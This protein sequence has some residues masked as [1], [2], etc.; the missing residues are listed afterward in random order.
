[1][2]RTIVMNA[3]VNGVPASVD[4]LEH[5]DTYKPNWQNAGVPISAVYTIGRNMICV[6]K[7]DSSPYSVELDMIAD[8]DVPSVDT[9]KL[10][11]G[12][13]HIKVVLGM[14][15]CI[16]SFKLGGSEFAVTLPLMKEF[17]EA[18]NRLNGKLEGIAPYRRL[19]GN[20]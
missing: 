2:D 6:E 13:E 20:V 4:K 17:M 18:A 14:A 10:Q 7:A 12:S 1:M 15:Q 3:S 11:V 19:M 5:L 8:I 9:D 16:A